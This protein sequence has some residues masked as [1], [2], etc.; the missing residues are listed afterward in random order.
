MTF[1]QLVIFRS[2]ATDTGFTFCLGLVAEPLYA[3]SCGCYLMALFISTPIIQFAYLGVWYSS[4]AF[5]A[6]V[7]TNLLTQIISYLFTDT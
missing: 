1:F 4:L 3:L 2:V 6:A 5:P 7:F